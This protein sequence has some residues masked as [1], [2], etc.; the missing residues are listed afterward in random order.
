MKTAKQKERELIIKL[1]KEKKKVR[2]IAQILGL[3]KSK[4]HFWIQRNRISKSLDDKPKS[5]R[6]TPLNA[7]ALKSIAKSIENKLI[8]PKNN[9]AGISTKEV[10]QLIKNKTKKKY[11]VR[12]VERIMHKMG[13]S[14]ITPRTSH[15][16]K[17]ENA[18]E[19]FK[20]EFKKNLSRNI[21][22]IQ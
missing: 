14:L 10:K 1:H 4:V 11:C 7:K 5:G 18:K 17:D 20:V 2:E 13:L 9:K 15:I 6:P 21:W 22:T 19:K 16:R 8:S 3:S 12:H